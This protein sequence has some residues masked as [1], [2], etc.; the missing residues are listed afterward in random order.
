MPSVTTPA[1]ALIR[2]A[3]WDNDWIIE[4]DRQQQ[5]GH[6]FEAHKGDTKIVVR[7]SRRGG[8]TYATYNQTIARGRDKRT[9]VIG[10]FFEPAA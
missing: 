3:A 5:G 7:F 1:V 2:D 10:W 6:V 8:I 4:R 9:T